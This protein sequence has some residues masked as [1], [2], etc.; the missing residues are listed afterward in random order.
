[1]NDPE[2]PS[3][4]GDC[5]SPT[6]PLSRRAHAASF[7]L[8]VSPL[9]TSP[10]R[11]AR[12]SPGHLYICILIFFSRRISG[13][14]GFSPVAPLTHPSSLL[15]VASPPAGRRLA[16]EAA[17]CLGE[18]LIPQASGLLSYPAQALNTKITKKYMKRTR[19]S[20]E[21]SLNLKPNWQNSI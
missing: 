3:P 13:P 8:A 17:G 19:I 7:P 15:R 5:N 9:E 14:A 4:A 16:E 18:V 21:N 12:G 2:L 6:D 11:P 20:R 1:M 10:R